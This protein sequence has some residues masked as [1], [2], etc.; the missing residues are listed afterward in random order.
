MWQAFFS[1]LEK[2]TNANGH[3]FAPT[4][5]ALAGR[6][7]SVAC[8]C[9][10]F[11]RK[12]KPDET[13]KQRNKAATSVWRR[14][15]SLGKSSAAC[16]TRVFLEPT[17]SLQETEE[18]AR[19]FEAAG[20][21]ASAA[22]WDKRIANLE[23][24][25]GALSPSAPEKNRKYMKAGSVEPASSFLHACLTLTGL[26]GQL[27]KQRAA[28]LAWQYIAMTMGRIRTAHELA[29]ISAAQMWS[30]FCPFHRPFL[31]ALALGE[32][33]PVDPRR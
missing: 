6:S 26:Q 9:I 21:L 11:H 23:K 30:L 10:L 1:H 7:L 17:Q 31:F 2:D 29:V 5:I 32:P 18:K 13:V 24:K 3:G 19:A 12:L 28:R 27:A 4:T 33:E 15:Q 22:A 14:C 8:Q 25:I 20:L 16:Q